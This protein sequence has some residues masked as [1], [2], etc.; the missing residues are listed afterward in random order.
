MTTQNIIFKGYSN[1]VE[2][3]FT[4]IADND[5]NAL[6]LN[7]LL[8][9]TAIF[10]NDSRNTTDNPQDV[11]VAGDNNELLQLYF[12]DTTE[13]SKGYWTIYGTFNT[14]LKLLTSCCYGNLGETKIC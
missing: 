13:I 3:E 14:E 2:I 8:P 6:T 1:K 12:G 10:K 11:I 9:I 4:G 7:D 5:G